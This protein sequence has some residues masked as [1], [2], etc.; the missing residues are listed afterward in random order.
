MMLTRKQSHVV[1]VFL[2]VTALTG[3]MALAVTFERFGFD[4]SLGF[5]LG[6]VFKA[7]VIGVVVGIPFSL[8]TFPILRKF[9][10]SLT[11]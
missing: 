9:V 5:F 11:A 2:I 7:W 10:D 8:F 6:R 1:F 4:H 3:V